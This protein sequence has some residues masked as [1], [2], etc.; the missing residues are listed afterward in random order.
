MTPQEQFAA[1]ASSKLAGADATSRAN[2]HLA[3]G[4]VVARIDDFS[5]SH[6]LVKVHFTDLVSRQIGALY[7][8]LDNPITQ[9]IRTRL[10]M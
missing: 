9:E 8:D 10:G 2:L 5:H 7:L 1:V 4:S 6:G 3:I